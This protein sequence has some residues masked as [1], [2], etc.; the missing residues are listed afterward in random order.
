MQRTDVAVEMAKTKVVLALLRKPTLACK[1]AMKLRD[2][3]GRL[4]IEQFKKYW[5]YFEPIKP[6]FDLVYASS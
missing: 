1:E 3:I 5:A 2:R 4:M 6:L